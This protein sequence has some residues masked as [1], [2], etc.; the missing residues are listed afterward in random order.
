MSAP[1]LITRD[2]LVRLR[3]MLDRG[4]DEWLAAS[5]EVKPGMWPQII[6]TLGCP[7][8]ED[9]VVYFI[10]AFAKDR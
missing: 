8:P 9:E 10:E 6:E 7:P 5:Y 3:D 1:F 4:D 2:Q